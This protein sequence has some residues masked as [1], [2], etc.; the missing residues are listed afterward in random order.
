MHE[1]NNIELDKLRKQQQPAHKNIKVPLF[2]HT[3]IFFLRAGF[4][5]TTWQA[6]IYICLNYT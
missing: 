1:S 2:N 4:E 5:V 3:H 6:N